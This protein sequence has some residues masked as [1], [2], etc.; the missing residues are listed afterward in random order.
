MSTPTRRDPSGSWSRAS[1]L[2]LL[3]GALVGCGRA[4]PTAAEEPPPAASPGDTAAPEEPAADADGPTLV[5][6]VASLATTDV[7]VRIVYTAQGEA[8]RQL[9]LSFGDGSAPL[10]VHGE[11]RAVLTDTI[12]HTFV[13]PGQYTL[14]AEVADYERRFTTRNRVVRVVSE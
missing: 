6:D 12:V 9:R 3:A 13:Q 10:S 2:L 8:L 14:V 7:P 4:Y 11:R 1:L 5:L